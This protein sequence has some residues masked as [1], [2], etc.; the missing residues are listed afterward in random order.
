MHLN[1]G[2]PPRGPRPPQKNPSLSHNAPKSKKLKEPW[3]Q[4][5]DLVHL[6][7]DGEE[8]RPHGREVGV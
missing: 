1:Q 8:L 3:A 7:R 4:N 5:Q 2:P 6:D